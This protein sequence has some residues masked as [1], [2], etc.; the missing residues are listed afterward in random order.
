MLSIQHIIFENKDPN[1]FLIFRNALQMKKLMELIDV[2]SR[3]RVK[4]IEVI[5]NPPPRKTK[6][7]EFYDEFTAGTFSTDEE[8]AQYF[9]GTDANNRNYKLLKKRLIEKLYNTALFIDIEQP[10]MGEAAKAYYTAW[11]DFAI[12]KVLAGREAN[13]NFLYLSEKTLI[14]AIKYDFDDLIIPICRQLR[15]YHS[16]QSF[17]QKKFDYYDELLKKYQGRQEENLLAEDFF[18]R[19]TLATYGC[20]KCNIPA[21]NKQIRGYL[22]I[23]D[24]IKENNDA[25]RFNLLYYLMQVQL[26]FNTS[27]YNKAINTCK[28][29]LI[30]FQSQP[31]FPG[32]ALGIFSR[33]LFLLYWQQRSFEKAEQLLRSAD[34][35]VRVG[36]QT[37]FL[38]YYHF[39]LLCL[40]ARRYQEAY[41]TLQYIVNHQ[42]F[43]TLEDHLQE[44]WRVA[45]AY[46]MFLAE[47]GKIKN[48][49]IK[50][51]EKQAQQKF[52]MGKFLNE[53]PRF[54][55]DKSRRNVPILIIQILFLLLRKEYLQVIDRTEAIQ[56]YASRHLRKDNKFR[57]NCFIKMLTQ[58][59]DAD[60]HPKAT[61]RKTA[62]LV[63][64]LESIP[65][66]VA[67]QVYDIEVLP[68]E[69]S[70]DLAMEALNR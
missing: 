69:H 66:E 49:Q 47:A 22:K 14:T 9:Y 43:S 7:Q 13:K 38:N 50:N 8:A 68:Y 61:Q 67:S 26:S 54:S 33:K 1:T 2:V 44:R 45:E 31:H 28:S 56:Q 21:L 32:N 34:N 65:F 20:K 37:Y 12:I 16:N 6:A 17:D 48:D 42:R 57:S 64:K 4:N 40:H 55:Q 30:F 39:T 19:M 59:V 27:Q 15:L 36:G 51:S 3:N 10:D 46:I 11:K 41:D 35:Y 60:F 24:P 70:W 63:K 23:L 5:G 53:V 62:F 52:R 29:A 58:I 25:Y 18:G